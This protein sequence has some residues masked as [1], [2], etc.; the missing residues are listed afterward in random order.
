M[1]IV[2]TNIHEAEAVLRKAGFNHAWLYDQDQDASEFVFLVQPNFLSAKELEDLTLQ[3]MRLF[4]GKVWVAE[5][6][7]GVASIPIF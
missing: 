6:R 4:P 5:K 1:A 3:L 2:P 7:P